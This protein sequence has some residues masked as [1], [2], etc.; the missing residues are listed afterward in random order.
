[1][2]MSGDIH[3]HMLKTLF[4]STPGHQ[5]LLYGSLAVN[6]PTFALS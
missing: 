3:S 5:W 2:P 6:R 4:T 1:M